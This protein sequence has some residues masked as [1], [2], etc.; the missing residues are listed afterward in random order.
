MEIIYTGMTRVEAK[1][2]L[3]S[4]AQTD[5]REILAQTIIIIIMATAH[6]IH[7]KTVME[8]IYTGTIPA[9]LSKI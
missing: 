3:C 6:T 7:T 5:A 1:E 9:E 2:T 4:I 8:I